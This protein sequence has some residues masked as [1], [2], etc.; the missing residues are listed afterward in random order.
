MAVVIM[1]VIDSSLVWLYCETGFL[2]E[3]RKHCEGIVGR[4]FEP[5]QD[6]FL[7]VFPSCHKLSQL[8]EHY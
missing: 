6:Y 7:L 2:I 3:F 4:Y 5:A 8:E 1:Q